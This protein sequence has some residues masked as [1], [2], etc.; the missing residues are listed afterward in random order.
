MLLEGVCALSACCTCV[1]YVALVILGCVFFLG[2]GCVRVL[3][4]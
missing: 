3:V 4:V 1:I 2:K